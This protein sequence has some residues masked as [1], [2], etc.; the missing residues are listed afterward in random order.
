[1]LVKTL[2]L[3]FKGVAHSDD[4]IYLFPVQD[5]EFNAEEV[6]VS[7]NLI[8]IWSNYARIGYKSK[9]FC[10]T[11]ALQVSLSQRLSIEFLI[12]IPPRIH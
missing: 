7:N 6:N 3:S 10:M 11:I 8:S 5:F 12:A 4:T 1:M 9:L 2:F